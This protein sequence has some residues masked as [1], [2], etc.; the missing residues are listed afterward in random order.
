MT[1]N[2]VWKLLMVVSLVALGI[3]ACYLASHR[4]YQVDEAQSLFMLRVMGTH[5]TGAYF[6]YPL[7]WMLGP[8]ARLAAS[9]HHSADLFFA[10][11][12]IF[13]G[14]F[15]LNVFLLALNTGVRLRSWQGLLA[16][17]G[18]ATLAPLWD[19]GFEIRHDNLIL[20]ALLFMWWLC[21][22]RPM[23]NRSYAGLG[24]V[25]VV[26]LF[27]AFK[28]FVYV[29]PLWLGFLVFPPPG[30]QEAR[31]RLFGSW[32]LGAGAGA[33]LVLT[34]YWSSGFW[35]F[36]WTVFKS[37]FQTSEGATR[38]GSGLALGRLLDQ[39]PLLLGLSLAGSL[40]LVLRL[41][42]EGRQVLNWEGWFPEVAL[43][44]GALGVI[45]VNP[46]PFPYNLINLV[47]FFYLLVIRILVT[48][49]GEFQGTVPL[50]VLLTGV[51]CFTH[52]LPFLRATW[53]HTERS[54]E[55]QELLMRTAEALT[56]PVKDRVYDAIG[57]VP[58]RPS[59]GFH[60]YLH[61][62]N[63]K[64][65][66]AGRIPS[67]SQMLQARP[68]AVLI[69]SYRTDWLPEADQRI[70]ADRYLPLA[71]DFWVLGKVM[72]PGGGRYTAV[73][74][75]RYKVFRLEKGRPAGAASILLDGKALEDRPIH[76]EAGDHLVASPPDTRSVVVW[77]GPKLDLPPQIG[78]G[79]HARLFVNWY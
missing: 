35:S 50:S 24:F 13:L 62:L 63:M 18:A 36:F 70:I 48:W 74:P 37:G 5:Q 44:L 53:R 61:S 16:I 22:T 14:V 56:D 43:C 68:A 59:I 73:H 21:R 77:V 10:A 25:G 72:P 65:F 66:A 32:L 6:T 69:K 60:W 11:R 55:R 54:N 33:V 2:L 39:T 45:L 7:L 52:L 4:I 19:Y 34:S 20:A 3:F 71:D 30:H 67:V 78:Q 57:M 76:L 58:T 26:L 17:L 1:R 9:A 47:P 15:L 31:G 75:G 51:I 79:D 41:R 12:A 64:D 23:G 46:T 49:R 8:L 28:S 27:V 38:F 29:I 42:T 40:A